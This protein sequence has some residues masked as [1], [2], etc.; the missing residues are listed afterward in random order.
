MKKL[1]PAQLKVL[2]ALAEPGARAFAM[3][4]SSNWCLTNR[5][6]RA[7]LPTILKLSKMGLTDSI[8]DDFQFIRDTTTITPAGREYLRGLEEAP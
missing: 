5:P 4:M 7:Q 1:S 2:K 8:Y 6:W 3:A